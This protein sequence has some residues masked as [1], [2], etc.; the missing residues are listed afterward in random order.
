M[1]I[2]SDAGGWLPASRFRS[3]AVVDLLDR[4][5]HGERRAQRRADMVRHLDRRVPERHH[6]V[7]HELVERAAGVEHVLRQRRVDRVQEADDV[8]GREPLGARGEAAD[9]GEQHGQDAGLAAEH[10]ARRIARQALDHGRR[11][12]VGEGVADLAP[13][14]LGPA[15]HR[16]AGDAE[17]SDRGGARPQRVEELLQ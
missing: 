2:A 13:L 3:Q 14:A 17:A 7:A 4:A 10:E 12:V 1:P 5:L 16:H 6:A 11:E 15:Q 9:V 8:L